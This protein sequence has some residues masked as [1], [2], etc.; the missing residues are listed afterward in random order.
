MTKNYL[1][2]A[3]TVLLTVFVSKA[4]LAATPQ[5]QYVQ[6]QNYF[7]KV[8]VETSMGNFVLQLN[9]IKS[10]IATDNF[11]SYVVNT[12]FD[13]TIV[14]RVEEDYLI[15]AGGYKSDYSE[16]EPYEPIF[17][18]SGNGLKNKLGTIAM[19]K[20]MNDAHSA[21]SQFFINLNNNKHLNPGRD[22][23]YPVFGDV[24]EGFEVIDAIGA[25]EVGVSP[26]L[27]YPTV[28]KTKI[29]I[30]RMVVLEEEVEETQE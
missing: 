8:R 14:H 30:I 28:P 9:R 17:N 2:I 23:G 7:P 26:E 27:G 25:V 21:T 6:P 22:W 29:T 3:L 18:E 19:A 5:G 11:L 10:K 12:D 1:I 13:N 16:I 20:Q 15:Q 24:V 4:V